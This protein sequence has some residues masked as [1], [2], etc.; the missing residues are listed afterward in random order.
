MNTD[1]HRGIDKKKNSNLTLRNFNSVND[2]HMQLNVPEKLK[3]PQCKKEVKFF[4][5]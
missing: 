3:P 4:H 1:K 2:L 5:Y